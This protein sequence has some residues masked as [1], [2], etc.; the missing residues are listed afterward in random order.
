MQDNLLSLNTGNLRL[1][2][3]IEQLKFDLK[4]RDR[5]FLRRDEEHQR[6][7]ARILLLLERQQ[8]TRAAADATQVGG[9]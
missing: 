3:D 2:N 1:K 5:D 8:S 9:S 4:E 7:L 6:K